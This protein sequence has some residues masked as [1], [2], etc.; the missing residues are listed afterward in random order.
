MILVR[1]DPIPG[2]RSFIV[3]RPDDNDPALRPKY[4]PHEARLESRLHFPWDSVSKNLSFKVC[5][6]AL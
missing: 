5:H 3:L 2:L 6:A 1:P 4:S